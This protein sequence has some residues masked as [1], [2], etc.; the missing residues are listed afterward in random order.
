FYSTKKN[1]TGLGLAIAQRIINNLNGRIEVKTK[2]AEGTAF[3]LYLQRYH[4]IKKQVC[5]VA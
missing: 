4:G 1:G 3:I 5:Q 2:L